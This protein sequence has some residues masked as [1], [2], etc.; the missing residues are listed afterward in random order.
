MFRVKKV[1][2]GYIVYTKRGHSHFP[3]KETCYQLIKLLKKHIKPSNPYMLESAR[4]L[5][6]PK[7][8]KN[9]KEEL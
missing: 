5:L 9:L 7:D 6:S 8:F 1:K 3:R 4:R 2:S